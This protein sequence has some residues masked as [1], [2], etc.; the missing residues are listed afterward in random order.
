MRLLQ[1]HLMQKLALEYP[2][3][4]FEKNAGYGTKAHIEGLQRYGVV[5]GVHRLSYRP[6]REI[7]TRAA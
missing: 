3:F 2:Y 5:A 1:D 6:V 4:G 7:L